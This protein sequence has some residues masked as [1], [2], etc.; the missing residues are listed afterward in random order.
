[1]RVVEDGQLR[2][3][4]Q[5]RRSDVRCKLIDRSDLH[6]RFFRTR[7]DVFDITGR[8]PKRLRLTICRPICRTLLSA[9]VHEINE[10][11]LLLIGIG[12]DELLEFGSFHRILDDLCPFIVVGI[13][14]MFHATIELSTNS[15]RI[16]DDDLLQMLNRTATVLAAGQLGLPRC[17]TLQSIGGENVVHQI[18]IKILNDGILI[19]VG[20]EQLC[21]YRRG[22]TVSAHVQIV[23]MFRGDHSKIFA[24]GLS[25]FACT[26]A[27]G[28]LHF[29]RGSYA[30]IAIL[31]AYG[32]RNAVLYTVATPGATDA[33]LDGTQRFAI[34]MPAFKTRLAQILPNIRQ[35]MLAGAEQ[36]DTLCSRDFA[37]ETVLFSGYAQCYQLL[38]RQFS[39]GD[40]W[41][42]G[43]S[44]SSLHVG[45]GSVIGVLQSIASTVQNDLIVQRCQHAPHGWFA[46]FTSIAVTV[47]F[48]YF[49]EGIHRAWIGIHAQ[50]QHELLT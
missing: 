37:V 49:R 40:A 14:Q 1:M 43:V 10:L 7:K 18:P 45:Q 30:F 22:T 19:N 8:L 39:T 23:A 26:S 6:P 21:M 47:L 28:R 15:E 41:D 24:D 13:H 12:V 5:N 50:F 4:V 44:S 25:A 16:F 11:V 9:H 33:A 3:T 35:L 36:I 46:D 27:D 20:S 31:H 2:L 32:E 29:V 42:D 17:R 48:Q 38:R 34:G